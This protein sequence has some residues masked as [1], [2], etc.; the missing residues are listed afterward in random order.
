MVESF[1][2]FS[3]FS[4]ASQ[5]EFQPRA[6]TPVELI[7]FSNPLHSMMEKFYPSCP[8]CGLKMYRGLGGMWSCW[9]Q[10]KN[11][12]LKMFSCNLTPQAF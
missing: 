8:H 2:S 12:P 3:P 6:L 11:N 5:T 9:C 10:Q 4:I 1:S 7:L